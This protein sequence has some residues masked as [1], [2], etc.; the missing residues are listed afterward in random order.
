MRLQQSPAV[1][2][3]NAPPQRANVGANTMTIREKTDRSI[4]LVFRLGVIATPLLL[5]LAVMAGFWSMMLF[6]VLM[7]AVLCEVAGAAL[8][9]AQGIRCPVCNMRLGPL[10][11][12]GTWGTQSPFRRC[13]Y[14]KTGFEAELPINKGQQGGGEERR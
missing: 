2:V 10:L 13:P 4:R 12:A 8:Y 5:T 6:N 9:L 1:Y 11:W 7:F 3:A 14:C